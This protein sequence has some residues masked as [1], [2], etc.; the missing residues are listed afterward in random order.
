VIAYGVGVLYI[1]KF[2][3]RGEENKEIAVT[4]YTMNY[5]L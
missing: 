3:K 4:G 2:Y 1:G 5:I